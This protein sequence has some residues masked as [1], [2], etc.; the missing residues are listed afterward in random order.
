MLFTEESCYDFIEK[1]LKDKEMEC[2]D[3]LVLW[4]KDL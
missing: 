4:M 1:M 3:L 2:S